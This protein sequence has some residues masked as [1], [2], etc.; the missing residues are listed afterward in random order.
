MAIVGGIK[1]SW[2]INPIWFK[3][4][5]SPVSFPFRMKAIHCR[6]FV[7]SSANSLVN[8]LGVADLASD[9]EHEVAT[10]E[11]V[12][13]PLVTDLGDE[14]R[15]IIGDVAAVASVAGNQRVHHDYFGAERAKRSNE[16]GADEPQST[17]DEA[18]R[19]GEVWMAR[20]FDGRWWRRRH[21][22]A[23]L[24]PCPAA[25]GATCQDEPRE[26]R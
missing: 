18:S 17:G 11:G 3:T 25:A 15:D 26:V 2:R 5:L 9:V 10:N 19:R 22:S 20:R 21:A 23:M 1:K 7:S 8:R 16:V 24:D 14:H 6:C 4:K 13:D 12:G